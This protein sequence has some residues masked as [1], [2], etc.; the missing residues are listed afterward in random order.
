MAS[1]CST[2]LRPFEVDNYVE[3]LEC[4]RIEEMFSQ[5]W[6]KQSCRLIQ[7]SVEVALETSHRREEY[8]QRSITLH[9]KGLVII[10]HLLMGESWRLHLLPLVWKQ[11]TPPTSSLPLML[12]L[13]TESA[14][15]TILESLV[16]HEESAEALD[17]LVLDVIDYCVRQLTFLTSYAQ[18]HEVPPYTPEAALKASGGLSNSESAESGEETVST[19]QGEVSEEKNRLCMVL[20]CRSVAVIQLL[21]ACRSKL[22]LCAMT[23]LLQTHDVPQLLATLLQLT[24]WKATHKDTA[25]D[26]Q[27]G[28]WVTEKDAKPSG[29]VNRIEGQIWVTLYT[30]LMDQETLSMYE[31][32]QGRRAALLKIRGKLNEA[33]LSHLPVLEPFAKWL[34]A[35]ALTTPQQA[36]PPPLVTTVRQLGDGVVSQWTGRWQE[37]FQILAPRCLSPSQESLSTLA[38]SMSAAWNLEALE[39]LLPDIPVCAVCGSPA[40]RRC[41]RC[42]M[43]WYC[44]REC[45]VKHWPTHQ[46]LCDV[47]SAVPSKSETNVID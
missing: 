21:T 25:Y 39:A 23:S 24:P 35:L 10:W 1:V 46:S 28:Q 31:L 6:V 47:I 22:P 3:N 17:A 42:R 40:G 18:Y 41:S 45:Q 29:P 37:L 12:V 43:Q 20:A 11:G 38:T 2:L 16:F 7:L 36:R 27:D 26:F 14:A 33:L 15:L 13:Q 5:R 9:N 4:I 32:S 30:L 34:S 8:V 44:R 19:I